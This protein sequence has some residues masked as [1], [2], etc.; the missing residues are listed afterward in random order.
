MGYGFVNFAT[1]GAACAFENLFKSALSIDW[2][3][4]QGL[5]ANIER[6]RNSPVMHDS[7]PQSFQPMLLQHG[8]QIPF[9][10]P[11]QSIRGP[12]IKARSR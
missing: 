1:P 5:G 10:C 6:Y 9:P 7:V 4:V 2:A 8:F 3:E 11:T 12:K